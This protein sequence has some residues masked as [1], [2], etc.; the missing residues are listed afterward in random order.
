MAA[1]LLRRLLVSGFALLAL[2]ACQTAGSDDRS[3]L[4]I[5]QSVVQSI[6][7]DMTSR[8]GEHFQPGTTQVDLGLENS[9]LADALAEALTRGGY[10]VVRGKPADQRQGKT[11][12]LAYHIHPHEGQILAT[13]STRESSLSRAYEISGEGAKPASSFS[14]LRRG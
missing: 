11:L 3:K 2:S 7:I 14:I 8:F 9:P 1:P 13:L 4:S 10:A 12:E 6:A 5:P